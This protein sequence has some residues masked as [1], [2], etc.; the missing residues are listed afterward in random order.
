[1]SL[2]YL[3]R[4]IRMNKEIANR[5]A[6]GFSDIE[7]EYTKKFCFALDREPTSIGPCISI[8]LWKLSINIG[9]FWE[10][11]ANKEGPNNE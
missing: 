10:P 3:K 1:M 2:P 5:I 11:Q 4:E 7:E 6:D 9:W 8:C